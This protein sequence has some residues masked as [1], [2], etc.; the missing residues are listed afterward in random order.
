M[1]D[2]AQ[3]INRLLLGLSYRPPSI[4]SFD[5]ISDISIPHQWFACTHLLDPYPIDRSRYDP[6]MTFAP[7]HNGP[8][9]ARSYISGGTG[10]GAAR[11]IMVPTNAP[12]AQ[13]LSQSEGMFSAFISEIGD[14]S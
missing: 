3:T 11:F 2:A 7:L 8:L 9:V 1:P 14:R 12:S 5:V 10:N 4:R 6:I 13:P